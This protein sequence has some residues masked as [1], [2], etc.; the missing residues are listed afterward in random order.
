MVMRLHTLLMQ[1]L[2]TYKTRRVKLNPKVEEKIAGMNVTAAQKGQLRA[3]ARL[4]ALREMMLMEIPDRWSDIL[5]TSVP[6]SNAKSAVPLFP[7][8]LDSTDA[9]GTK[10]RTELANAYLRRYFQ[11]AQNATTSADVERLTDNQG[12]ECL[13]LV[14]TLACGDGETRTLFHESNIGDTDGDGAKEFLDG[15]NRP[16][17]FL[18]WAPGFDSEIQLNANTLGDPPPLNI[19]QNQNWESA[20]SRDHDP[21]DVFRVEVA[22]FRLVPVIF[23]AG[24]DETFGVRLVKPHVA[25]EGLANAAT[26]PGSLATLSPYR[27]VEDPDPVPTFVYLGTVNADGTA[28]DNIHNHVLNQR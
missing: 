9:V 4:N 21:F 3:L 6:A 10:G 24:R 28:T 15:W 5:L 11:Y 22:A 8:Y 27:K 1:H 14:I 17:N 26:L 18:R 16:I 13:Y 23:S 2:D 12:A 7:I 25:W 20:A 19:G